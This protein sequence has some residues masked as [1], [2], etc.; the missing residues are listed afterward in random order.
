M[1]LKK[2]FRKAK[3]QYD[4]VVEN[5]AQQ[6]STVKTRKVTVITTDTDKQKI[7]GLNKRIRD[8]KEKIEISDS[9]ARSLTVQRYATWNYI[10][11]V[12]IPSGLPYIDVY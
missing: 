12:Y 7:S 2:L 10:V 5:A 8:L 9:K 1:K 3:T 6:A 11:V 4:E